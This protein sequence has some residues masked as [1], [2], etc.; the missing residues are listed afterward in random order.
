M[1]DEITKDIKN[2][3]LSRSEAIRV[4]RWLAKQTGRPIPGGWTAIHRLSCSQ[5]AQ[6]YKQSLDAVLKEARLDVLIKD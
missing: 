1:L 5:I 2:H 3:P 4:A 6:T